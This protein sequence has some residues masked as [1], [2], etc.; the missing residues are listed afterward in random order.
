[1]AGDGC[2]GGL[3]AWRELPQELGASG[4][5]VHAASRTNYSLAKPHL[6]APLHREPEHLGLRPVLRRAPPTRTIPW[7]ATGPWRK[8]FGRRSSGSWSACGCRHGVRGS[9]RT[10]AGGTDQVPW[11]APAVRL[12]SNHWLGASRHGLEREERPQHDQR[13]EA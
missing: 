8:L 2:R 11:V 12:S 3:R 5:G 9:L 13:V 4:A 7:S 6:H 1:M 10:V